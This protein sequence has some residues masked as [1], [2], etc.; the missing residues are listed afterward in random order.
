M[1]TNK[2]RSH[3]E[4]RQTRAQE[5]ET[6]PKNVPSLNVFLALTGHQ[7]QTEQGKEGWVGVAALWRPSILY[8]QAQRQTNAVMGNPASCLA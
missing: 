4:E 5:Q 6:D 3:Y 8:S 2:G 1:E 7:R